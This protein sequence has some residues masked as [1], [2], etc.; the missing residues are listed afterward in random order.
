[1]YPSL[2]LGHSKDYHGTRGGSTTPAGYSKEGWLTP[3]SGGLQWPCDSEDHPGTP[4]L[5]VG[6]FSGFTRAALRRID[7][8]PTEEQT[9][10]EFP[11]LSGRLG[12]RARVQSHCSPNR[13]WRTCLDATCTT[14]IASC[15]SGRL[16]GFEGAGPADISAV[17]VVPSGS[18]LHWEKLDADF[19]VSG[20]V[21]GVFGNKAWMDELRKEWGR[22]G[23]KTKS[24]AKA[25]AA[26]A[27]GARG[28]R[29]RKTARRA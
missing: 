7:Y 25:V 10:S 26:R 22:K 2:P 12:R 16:Q 29:P 19:S 23:G 5:H 1:M 14:L 20:L 4:I 13:D 28:G 6:T 27:N 21:A 3:A 17:E 18:A 8:K 11:F 9:N 24:E 15:A